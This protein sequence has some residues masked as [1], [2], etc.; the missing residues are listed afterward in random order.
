LLVLPRSLKAQLQLVISQ[1]LN[2]S[3]DRPFQ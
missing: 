2:L 1:S 3:R